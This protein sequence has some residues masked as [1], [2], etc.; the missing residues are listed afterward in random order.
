[1]F[2][3]NIN[4]YCTKTRQINCIVNLG[5]DKYQQI[6]YENLKK[7]PSMIL[8]MVININRYCTKTSLG[9]IALGSHSKININRYC[10]KTPFIND[11]VIKTIMI[12]INRYCTKTP[13]RYLIRLMS[14]LININSYCIK[15]DLLQLFF[16]NK[17][18]YF[19]LI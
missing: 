8:Y 6:L 9:N 12:N 7:S 16:Y 11:I 10:T 18:F 17:P 1:M 14:F 3:I 15:K 4:R 19:A 2:L 5:Q 13:F